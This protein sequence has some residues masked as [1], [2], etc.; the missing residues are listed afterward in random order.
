MLIVL[1]FGMLISFTKHHHPMIPKLKSHFLNSAK[2]KP[3]SLGICF[4][5]Q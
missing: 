1:L 4:C 2:A 5:I 3:E